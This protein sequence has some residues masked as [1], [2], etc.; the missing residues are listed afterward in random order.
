VDDEPLALEKILEY[1]SRVP[2][3]VS[4]GGFDNAI[5]ALDYMKEHKVDL[6]FLDIQMEELTGIQMLE[7]V[8]DPPR[9]V[10]TTAYSEYAIKSYELDVSDYL[11]KPISFSRF[12]KACEKVSVQLNQS[13]LKQ[14]SRSPSTGT[15][16][17]NSFIYVQSGQKMLKVNFEDIYFIEGEKDYVR[18]W[19]R[20]EKIMTLL[21]FKKLETLLPSPRFLRVHKSYLIAIDKI[22]SIERNRAEVLGEQIPIG[23]SYQRDFFEI[24]MKYKIN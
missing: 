21:S 18:I 6:V 7:I 1:I 23:K 14:V 16:P 4:L 9:V 24:I 8:K 20:E 19:T 15:S 10:L 11:L 5:S 17:E 2:Y 3:L 12:L 22:S 13:S